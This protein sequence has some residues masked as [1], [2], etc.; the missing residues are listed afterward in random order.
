MSPLIDALRG[1]SSGRH[2]RVSRLLAEGADPNVWTEP[3]LFT[4]SALSLAMLKSWELEDEIDED[5]AS[6]LASLRDR[7]IRGL[8]QAVFTNPLE[9]LPRGTGIQKDDDL[10][11]VRTEA[12]PW[13]DTDVWLDGRRALGRRRVRDRALVPSAAP[14]TVTLDVPAEHQ[15]S[16]LNRSDVA[17]W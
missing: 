14:Q 10:G 13:S 16:P 4:A 5:L 15:N 12:I 6:Y 3:G 7:R 17:A 1:T 9:F 2:E 8:A 11:G